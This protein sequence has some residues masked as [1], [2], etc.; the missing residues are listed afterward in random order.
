MCTETSMAEANPLLDAG[1][2]SSK[3]S[4]CLASVIGMTADVCLL[5]PI[6]ISGVFT[7]ILFS[8]SF[9]LEYRIMCP[10]I[11]SKQTGGDLK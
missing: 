11:S 2:D 5:V 3:A 10:K 8:N 1:E 4:K 7:F 9:D 6:S